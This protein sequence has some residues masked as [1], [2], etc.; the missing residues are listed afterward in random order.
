MRIR[1]NVWALENDPADRTLH[2]YAK[3]IASMKARPITQHNSW[4][5]QAAIH[6]YLRSQD[7]LAVQGE[8]L[9]SAS[10]QANFWNRCQHNSWF[11]LA[12][13]RMYL[14]LFEE[15]VAAEVLSQGGPDDWALPYWNYSRSVGEQRLPPSFRLPVDGTGASNE[16]YLPQRSGAANGGIPAGAPS[17]DLTQVLRVG[18]YSVPANSPAAAFCGVETGFRRPGQSKI[19]NF[20]Q[21]VGRFSDAAE[22]G[23]QCH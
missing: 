2:W 20:L 15:I 13:H 9:P 11:F 12:W 23:E 17:T 14:H 8:A 3:A 4:R 16:L 5:F 19:G 22:A 6:Q 21:R 10:D 18:D 1:R 7:P